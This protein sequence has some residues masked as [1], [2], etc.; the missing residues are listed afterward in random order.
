MNSQ[1]KKIIL[2]IIVLVLSYFAAPL[3]GPWYDSISVQDG[4]LIGAR[5]LAIF[6][7]GLLISYIFLIPLVYG[8]FGIKRNKKWIIWSLLPVI[9]LVLMADKYHF[10][11]PV[12]LITTALVIAWVV[13]FIIS[14]FKRPNP[15]MVIR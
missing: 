13:R 3:V 10:Y 15:P 11:I 2:F 9:L 7:A 8:L 12:L 6:F 5:N 4:G 1:V 14:K